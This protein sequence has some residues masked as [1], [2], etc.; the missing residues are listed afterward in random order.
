MPQLN[1]LLLPLLG[2]Y[3]FLS[4]LNRT[5]YTLQRESGYELA[6][7]SMIAG[8]ILLGFAE[9][10]YITIIYLQGKI[11][12]IADFVNWWRHTVRFAYSGIATISFLAGLCLPHICNRLFFD[13]SKE[14]SRAIQEEGE[15]FE[16]ILEKA[17]KRTKMVS[18]TLKNN[19]VYIGAVT[20]NYL[21]GGT[22][23]Y[24]KIIPFYSGY[25]T[26]PDLID[27]FK[28]TMGS[29]RGGVYVESEVHRGVQG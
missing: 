14:L 13:K 10:P 18:I 26:S 23:R 2:G 25:W 22:R 6:F 9:V 28:G 12:L 4:R 5:K 24:L 16:Q 1:L 21:P 20:S 19:K 17:I 8:I 11:T 15:N 27:R 29:N 3:Y 7:S